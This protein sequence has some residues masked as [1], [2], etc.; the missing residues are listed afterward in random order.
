MP[1][2]MSQ[3]H[4]IILLDSI[5]VQFQITFMHINVGCTNYK[6]QKHYGLVL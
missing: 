1:I 2:Y 3:A 4:C 6:P 5:V